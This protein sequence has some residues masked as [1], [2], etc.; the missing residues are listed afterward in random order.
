MR[1]NIFALGLAAL[2]LSSLPCA[3][4]EV[5]VP[6]YETVSYEVPFVTTLDGIDA[7]KEP[8]AEGGTLVSLSY[9]TPAYAINEF[10]DKDLT[11][12]KT[13]QVYLPY[14]YEEGKSYD[15]LY[16]LHGT[17][18]KDTYWFYD[19][20]PDTTK[21][22]LDQM[23]SQGL[24]PP[25]IVVTPEY[26]SEIS[27]RETR[28]KDELVEAY[29]EETG[30]PYLKVR[31]DLWTEYFHLELENDIIPLVETTYSTYAGGDVS[32]ESL[33]ASRA[34]RALAGLSRGSMATVRAGLVYNLDSI[35]WFGSFSGIWCPMERVLSSL[36]GG[37]P[38]LYWY[39]G[40]GTGDFAAEN[41]LT[42]FNEAKE[43]LADYL[44]DGENLCMVVKDGGAHDYPS[45]VVDL[46]NSLLV[47]FKE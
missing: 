20:E 6:E 3:A 31:N 46:Y 15:V 4:Q 28:V 18:G 33:K 11:I 43:T 17:G 29:A 30:D 32:P 10:L 37:E 8:C 5:V 19:A 24:C 1:K 42:F 34:H 7:L 45:W 23:I 39:N 38:V 27:G 13:L 44:Q 36:E 2:M 14:G 40:T 25:V 12:E 35:G 21:N 22:V 16:L 9:E 47:F 26:I 41:H